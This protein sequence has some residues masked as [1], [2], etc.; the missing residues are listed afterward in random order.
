MEEDH[1]LIS[2]DAVQHGLS[3]GKTSVSDSRDFGAESDSYGH[4]NHGITKTKLLLIKYKGLTFKVF[5]NT[6]LPIKKNIYIEPLDRVNL[7]LSYFFKIMIVLP[8]CHSSSNQQKNNRFNVL[9]PKL[10]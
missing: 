4:S 5:F 6:I 3:V 2:Y 7:S 10:N 1:C 9:D 8:I